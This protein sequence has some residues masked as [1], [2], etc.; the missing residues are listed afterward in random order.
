MSFTEQKIRLVVADDHTLVRQGIV[1]MLRQH[2]EFDVVCE[3]EDGVALM[4]A[5]VR[6]NPDVVLMDISMPKMNGLVAIDRVLQ[7]RSETKV[8]VLTMHDEIEYMHALHRAGAKGYLL[9][10]SSTDQLAQAIRA[11][12]RGKTFFPDVLLQSLQKEVD[13][14]GDNTNVLAPLTRREREVFFLV[15]AG[16]TTKDIAQLLDMSHKTAENHRGRILKKMQV[17]NTAELIRLAA[18]KGILE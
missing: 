17:E 15:I 4:Q 11:I 5:V 13:Q 7:Q 14:P 6:H 12:N 16:H 3:C 1:Q 10:E 9:K 2:E 18:R 8:L